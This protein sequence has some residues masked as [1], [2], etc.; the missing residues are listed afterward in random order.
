MPATSPA[1]VELPHLTILWPNSSGFFFLIIFTPFFYSLT[2]QVH[3]HCSLSAAPLPLYHTKI[4][5][6]QTAKIE[7]TVQ[8]AHLAYKHQSQINTKPEHRQR[9]L[10][11]WKLR[12]EEGESSRCSALLH[13]QQLVQL[14]HAVGLLQTHTAVWGW[15][16]SSLGSWHQRKLI[17]KGACNTTKSTVPAEGTCSQCGFVLERGLLKTFFKR[18]LAPSAISLC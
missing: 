15:S 6:K 16:I 9:E 11:G 3:C 14:S 18:L 7:Q 17:W 2:H 12:H 10:Q 4:T 5:E 8:Q 13:W 1:W